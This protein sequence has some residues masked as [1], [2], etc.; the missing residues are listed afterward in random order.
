MNVCV[1]STAVQ[2][3]I[4]DVWVKMSDSWQWDLR[5]GCGLTCNDCYFSETDVVVYVVEPPFVQDSATFETM[6]KGVGNEKAGT[7][8]L[9]YPYIALSLPDKA[10]E[11]QQKFQSI[12]VNAKK[13]FN[14]VIE[15]VF[16]GTFL[17]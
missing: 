13:V 14:R 8:I 3:E 6:L 12:L 10:K 5:S 17:I 1:I 2:A 9:V 7:L 4:P 11:I 15:L 16:S